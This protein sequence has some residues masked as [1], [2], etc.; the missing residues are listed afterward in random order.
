LTDDRQSAAES[1]FASGF[2]AAT[3]KQFR[4]GLMDL[5]Y[6]VSF[7]FGRKRWASTGGRAWRRIG[8]LW[9]GILAAAD[10]GQA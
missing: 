9:S 5:V 1:A 6:S 7:I 3:W 8:S 4:E 2:D 10:L